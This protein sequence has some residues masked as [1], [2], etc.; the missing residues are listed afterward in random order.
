LGKTFIF[1]IPFEKDGE[2]IEKLEDKFV[3]A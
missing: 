3:Q 2:F 1:A